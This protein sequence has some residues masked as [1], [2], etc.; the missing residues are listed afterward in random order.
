MTRYY[1]FTLA[2]A[3]IAHCGPKTRQ[4]PGSKI[5]TPD[6]MQSNK[7]VTTKIAATS[8]VTFLILGLLFWQ[9]F[10]G[11]VPSHHILQQ[12]DLPEISN[13]WGGLLLPALTWILWGRLETRLD[14]QGS[15]TQLAN[16]NSKIIGLLLMGL[17]LGVSIAVS[18]TYD[19]NFFLDN[20]LYVFLVLGFFLP[21]YYAEFILGFILGMTYTFGAVLPTV[22]IL[23]IAGFGFLLY[24]LLRPLVLKATKPFRK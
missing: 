22:F 18:F 9:H 21:L 16:Q 5:P 10:H 8:I 13:W 17:I 12:K 7:A 19:Y 20:V 4:N 24:G 11:G 6:N 15:S 2:S 3:W 23:I 1:W 14:K